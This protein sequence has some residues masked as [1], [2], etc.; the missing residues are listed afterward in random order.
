MNE[1]KKLEAVWQYYA[2]GTAIYIILAVLAAKLMS[3]AS[4]QISTG[5]L[6]ANPL[7]SQNSTY[8]APAT[9]VLWSIQFRWALVIL[10]ALSIVVPAIYIYL[11][12][13]NF[14]KIDLYKYRFIDWTVTGSFMLL[15]IAV[16]S[17]VSDI[18]TLVLIAGLS[19]VGY[20]LFWIIINNQLAKKPINQTVYKIGVL[21]TVL[22]WLLIVVYA[23]GTWVYGAIRMP[24]YVY[25]VYA[26]GVFNSAVII[27]ACFWHKTHDSKGSI[28]NETY[29]ILINQGIKALF[30]LILII[31][32]KR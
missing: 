27:Y 30:V 24:W 4:F 20:F 25:V 26:F 29:P 2:V 23:L 7:L 13:N 1:K 3:G 12:N 15:L 31:G 10:M 17:G 9:H 22:P 32:L 11:I 8:F 16:L 18:M 21:A 5:Y 28:T 6:T 19:V 14:K